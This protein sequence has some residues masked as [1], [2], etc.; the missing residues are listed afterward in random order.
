MK[1]LVPIAVVVPALLLLLAV[2]YIRIKRSGNLGYL[3]KHA[4]KT[5]VQL[6][7]AWND[8]KADRLRRVVTP[9]L[10]S[11]YSEILGVMNQRGIRNHLSDIRIKRIA[12]ISADRQSSDQPERYSAYISGSIV[13]Y[14]EIVETGHIIRNPGKNSEEFSDIYHFEK[15]GKK[16]KLSG[17]KNDVVFGEIIKSLE[18]QEFGRDF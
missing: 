5:F 14:S 6:Q 9:Q 15:S 2:I 4:A 18:N 17:V 16:W 12:I 8:G 13:H 1:V 11:K 7:R 10:F 3:K